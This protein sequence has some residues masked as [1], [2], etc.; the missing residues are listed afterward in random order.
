[1]G[2]PLVCLK[3]QV[4][5]GKDPVSGPQFPYHQGVW[6]KTKVMAIGIGHRDMKADSSM[7]STLISHQTIPAAK[8]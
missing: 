2:A 3:L 4:T 7:S 8:E 1:M 6:G 5:C